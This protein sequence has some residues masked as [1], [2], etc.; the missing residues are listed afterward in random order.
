MCA[1][2]DQ[3]MQRVFSATTLLIA[4]AAE[5]TAVKLTV[6]AVLAVAGIGM[7]KARISSGAV[8]TAMS[9]WKEVWA[10]IVTDFIPY[11]QRE[12]P[13]KFVSIAVFNRIIFS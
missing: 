2:T 11:S 3:A 9:T 12:E 6:A 10:V 5:A 4:A 1:R 7:T 8:I 13:P